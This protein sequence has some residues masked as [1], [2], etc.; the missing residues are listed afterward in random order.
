MNKTILKNR[1]VKEV[2]LCDDSIPDYKYTVI[3]KAGYR[4]WGYETHTKN[5]EGVKHF[6]RLAIEPCPSNCHCKDADMETP[7][8]AQP[9]SFLEVLGYHRNPDGTLT[10]DG[11]PTQK[12]VNKAEDF[13]INPILAAALDD[14]KKETDDE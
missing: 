3:L 7:V 4:F 14:I 1:F 11:P 10:G 8:V 2:E 12:K 13:M 9:R 5:V 6:Q